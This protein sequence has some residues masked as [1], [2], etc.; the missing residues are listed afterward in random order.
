MTL[1]PCIL[2]LGVCFSN[3][4]QYLLILVCSIFH[5]D[6][7]CVLK[8]VSQTGMC[9]QAAWTDLCPWEA[10]QTPATDLKVG[11]NGQLQLY[12]KSI[13]FTSFC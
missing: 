2:I 3:W 13:K 10:N 9:F 1:K 8:N 7:K 4:G 11:F 5:W 12:S 6:K